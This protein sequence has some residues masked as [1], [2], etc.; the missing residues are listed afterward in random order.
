MFLL[1]KLFNFRG[2]SSPEEGEKPFMAHLEDLR[3]MIV[4][5]VLTLILSTVLCYVFRGELMDLLRRPIE[6]VWVKS[7]EAKLPE[8]ISTTKWE[9]AKKAA[10]DTANL[11][12]AQR[13]HFFAQFADEELRHYAEC[14]TFY[15]SALILK[16]KD[17]QKDFIKTLPEIDG[18]TRD[19]VLELL[20]KNPNAKV[21]ARNNVVYMR[22]LRP[23]E[24]FMLS[25]KLAFFAG[26]IVSFPLLMYFILQFVIP[27][28][29]A[30]ERKALWPALTIGFGLFLLGVVFCY[31]FVLPKTLDFFYTYSQ[32]LG[33][34]N[35]WRIGDYI[36]FVTQF[37][38]I[39]GLAFELP[40]V[41]MTLVK[42]GLLGYET[43]KNTRGY[44]VLTI[45][46]VAAIITPTG[47]ALTLGMLA[48]P[49]IILYEIC[50]WLAFFS[51]K[52]E[53][54]DEEAELE[55]I[56]TPRIAPV[57]G[58]IDTH[59][60]HDENDETESDEHGDNHHEDYHVY[61]DDHHTEV[62]DDD[63]MHDEH[64]DYREDDYVDPGDDSTEDEGDEEDDGVLEEFPEDDSEPSDHADEDEDIDF[65]PGASFE[66]DEP[67][68]D[69]PNS[70]KPGPNKPKS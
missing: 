32:D 52:K 47:D 8:R 27:G 33:V 25:F 45:V 14:A 62:A 4:R 12:P 61:D 1:K 51:R 23:T 69:E 63:H 11:S 43:M 10:R 49:M 21:D 17:K 20:E 55:A 24:T 9:L 7:Q 58:I 46:I 36:S 54:E 44:A 60:D 15:R 37:T 26:V 66:A 29:K 64:H 39:F 16:D 18:E 57:P 48:V 38:L 70:D 35:E 67:D 56:R 50:I 22:S 2:K 6:T 59:D 5:V 65:N 41:V 13:K 3:D 40:V 68:S 34:E 42:I 30:K 31:I 28:L 19:T 53:I